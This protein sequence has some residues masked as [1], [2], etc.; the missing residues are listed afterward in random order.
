[1]E[2]ALLPAWPLSAA[3]CA[4]MLVRS[5]L[6]LLAELA[7]MFRWLRSCRDVRSESTCLH[8]VLFAMGDPELA[9]GDA[10]LVVG[11][12]ELAVG[13]AELAVGDPERAIAD[14]ECVAGLVAGLVVRGAAAGLLAL[15]LVVPELHAAMITAAPAISTTPAVLTGATGPFGLTGP[16]G[17]TCDCLAMRIWSPADATST[18]SSAGEIAAGTLRVGDSTYWTIAASTGRYA[19][20][21]RY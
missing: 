19:R 13:D 10:E 3:S 2:S 5:A 6:I 18:S 11:E 20:Y 17:L 16:T 14:P 1:V 4:W 7:L 8:V 15:L 21:S 9:V 12:A